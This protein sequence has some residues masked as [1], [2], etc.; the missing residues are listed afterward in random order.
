M[1]RKKLLTVLSAAGVMAAIGLSIP[2]TQNV[3][4]SPTTIKLANQNT[5]ESNFQRVLPKEWY[6]QTKEYGGLSLTISEEGKV[7]ANAVANPESVEE[8]LLYAQLGNGAVDYSNLN[9]SS[10]TNVK[11]VVL[12]AN[13][14]EEFGKLI[15]QIPSFTNLYVSGSLD[16]GDN[17]ANMNFENLYLCYTY[18]PSCPASNS[19]FYS[20]LNTSNIKHIYYNDFFATNCNSQL[21]Y[22]TDKQNKNSETITI[23][24][25]SG[26]LKYPDEVFYPCSDFNT[27]SLYLGSTGYFKAAST[28]EILTKSNLN[29]IIIT[30]DE[31][32]QDFVYDGTSTS[33]LD[34]DHIYNTLVMPNILNYNVTG[35]MA[36][37][38][39]VSINGGKS[40]DVNYLKGIETLRFLP[41][42]NGSGGLIKLTTTQYDESVSNLKQILIPKGYESSFERLTSRDDLTPIIEY[43]DPAEY[44]MPKSSSFKYND[45]TIRCTGG[46][47]IDEAKE[48]VE[49]LKALGIDYKSKPIDE[50]AEDYELPLIYAD[51]LSDNYSLRDM[52]TVILF[53]NMD[54]DKVI[55]EFKDY[56]PLNNGRTCD[57]EGFSITSI[58]KDNYTKGS[59]GEI[60]LSVKFKDNTVKD[61]TLYVKQLTETSP[62]AYILD[63][64]N[65]INVIAPKTTN[66]AK[67]STMVTP[68]MENYLNEASVEY[69]ESEILD[70]TYENLNCASFYK[71]S[72]TEGKIRV[73]TTSV[74]LTG[75]EIT[76]PGTDTP[77]DPSTKED[78]D[79]VDTEGYVMKEITGIYTTSKIDG[80]KLLSGLN[81]YMLRYNDK[82]ISTSFTI[83]YDP[84]DNTKDYGMTISTDI[85]S[86]DHYKHDVN[87]K[88]ITNPCDMGFVT[89]SD[90]SIAVEYYSGSLYTELEVTKGVKAFLESQG[91]PSD[92]VTLNSKI[93]GRR[94]Y[95]GAYQNGELYFVDSLYN[96]TYNSSTNPVDDSQ[97][98]EGYKGVTE[99]GYSSDYTIEEALRIVSRN[100][101]LVDG[102]PVD[103][104]QISFTTS[105]DSS[106][107][108]YEIT[109]DD[110]SLYKGTAYMK[111]METNY[112]YVYSRISQ[113]EYANIYI[114]KLDKAPDYTLNDVM[115]DFISQFRT[116]I[117]EFKNDEAISFTKTNDTTLAGV[118]RMGNGE[119]VNYEFNVYVDSNEH[120]IKSN[121]ATVDGKDEIGETFKDKFNN[122]F[123][124]FKTKFEENNI[125]KILT[126]TLGSILGLGILYLIFK[127]LRWIFRLFKR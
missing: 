23:E 124:S 28:S 71:A 29:E 90:G 43:Y 68:L 8:L 120:L 86:T 82:I 102:K 7:T 6:G 63:S 17:L 34:K 74:S 94:T 92:N 12:V 53:N 78:T 11:D 104:Y 52:K 117:G 14:P 24:P 19:S 91:L 50:I 108:G 80:T 79:A 88:I 48:E 96:I 98:K 121:K 103:D 106:Y 75:E 122:F 76:D 84:H 113:F 56:M 36:Y 32:I 31:S 107:V 118:Y 60:T 46:Y 101:L 127:L 57:P 58:N 22:I 123:D 65:N 55:E 3:Y 83:A 59:D 21:T 5:L 77:T 62:Y 87:V 42:I 41:Q 38:L 51:T 93:S 15:T 89:F 10:Y 126:I 66:K 99:I 72:T 73:A 69:T 9:L 95:K 112:K 20:K 26:E 109:K 13:I 125:F 54:I 61:V 81:N 40:L 27:R 47:T 100:M 70:T 64:N 25:I 115:K 4:A 30:I 49:R 111:K 18:M 116:I 44:T 114:D 39:D 67:L 33:Y 2:M 37:E 97:A 105:K 119:Y 16:F 85:T 110:E 35:I 45:E 1:K